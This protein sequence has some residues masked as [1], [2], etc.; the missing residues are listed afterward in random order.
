MRPLGCRA[1]DVGNSLIL[2]FMMTIGVDI[3]TLLLNVC[4]ASRTS[5]KWTTANHTSDAYRRSPVTA[6]DAVR[7]TV[8]ALRAHVG[9]KLQRPVGWVCLHALK[10]DR[11]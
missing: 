9:A 2:A 7:L 3:R 10:R 1:A 8:A 4:V 11:P 5:R 6:V